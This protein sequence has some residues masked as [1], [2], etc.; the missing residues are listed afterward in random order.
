M[1]EPHYIFCTTHGFFRKPKHPFLFTHM[2][3]YRPYRNIFFF[4]WNVPK[5]THTYVSIYSPTSDVRAQG[6]SIPPCNASKACMSDAK[7]GPSL[8]PLCAPVTCLVFDGAFAM[9]CGSKLW[10]CLGS[11]ALLKI[12]L[13]LGR[14]D[15]L[16]FCAQFKFSSC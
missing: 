8:P 3:I 15:L 9:S 5:L 2:H 14:R 10:L 13:C 16:R 11:R 6:C 12:W 4:N 7:K 1:M